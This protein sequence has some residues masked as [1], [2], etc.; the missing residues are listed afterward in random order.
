VSETVPRGSEEASG[1]RERPDQRRPLGAFAERVAAAH[2]ERRGYRIVQ[3]NVHLRVGEIDLVALHDGQT[4]LVEVRSRR[5][6]DLGTPL[7]SL[8]RSK[9]RRMRLTAE[10]FLALHPEL[11]EEARI[12]LVA[13][14]LS[15]GG[16]VT[17]VDI[18]PNAV[19]GSA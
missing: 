12:D 4:V 6:G 16:R 2:L 10:A 3:R 17:G 7:A 9:Q 13:V 14:T 1:R 19:D 11:P 15:R 5:E 18:V 8:S